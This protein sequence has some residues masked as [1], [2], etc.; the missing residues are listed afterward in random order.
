M[1]TLIYGQTKIAAPLNFINFITFITFI[2]FIMNVFYI[3]VSTLQLAHARG[4][5]H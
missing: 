5:V 2:T 1:F 3:T 4:G